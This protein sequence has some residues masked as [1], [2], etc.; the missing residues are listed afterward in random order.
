MSVNVGFTARLNAIFNEFSFLKRY[1]EIQTL[2]KVPVVSRINLDLLDM[3]PFDKSWLDWEVAMRTRCTVRKFF[4]IDSTGEEMAVVKPYRKKE[5]LKLRCFIFSTRKKRTIPGETVYTAITNLSEIN[6]V[7]FVV[8]VD[9]RWSRDYEGSDYNDGVSVII[10]KTP[11]SRSFLQWIDDL[12]QIAH[13]ELKKQIE[14]I[15]SLE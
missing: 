10:Y 5:E 9:D 1:V 3:Y 11:A 13:I 15:D 8:Q 14:Q 7:G 4:I 2:D 6:N 12:N